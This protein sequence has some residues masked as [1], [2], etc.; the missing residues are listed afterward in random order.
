MKKKILSQ[1][2]TVRYKMFQ[3]LNRNRC[4]VFYGFKNRN[5]TRT[6]LK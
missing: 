1:I 2:K 5:I 4:R 3:G 6:K